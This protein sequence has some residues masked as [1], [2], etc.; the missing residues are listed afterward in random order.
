LKKKEL[1]KI[2]QSEDCVFVHHGSNHDW[3]RNPK[4]EKNQ[5]IPENTEIEDG[6]TKRIIKKLS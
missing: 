5:S 1:L 4:T 3:Y 2:I 6:L